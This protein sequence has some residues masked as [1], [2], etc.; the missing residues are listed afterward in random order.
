MKIETLRA[1]ARCCS[2]FSGRSA[3]ERHFHRKFE[4]APHGSA[5]FLKIL[6]TLSTGARFSQNFQDAPHGSA[7]LIIRE[8]YGADQFSIELV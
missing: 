7:I 8:R 6:K 1:G 3:R 2:K 5:I 4:D